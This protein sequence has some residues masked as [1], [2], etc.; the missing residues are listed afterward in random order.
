V[1]I[2]DEMIC[3]ATAIAGKT[4]FS[5]DI[6]SSAAAGIGR[7]LDDAV[8]L[9]S[10]V[11]IPGAEW[12]LRLPLRSSRRFAR[13]RAH[14][15]AAIYGLIG[16]RR[17][18]P[19]AGHDLLSMLLQAQDS[20]GDGERMTDHQVRDEALTLFLTALDTVSLSLTWVW[21]ALARNPG[22][23]MTLWAELEQVLGGRP[24]AVEDLGSLP[25]TRMVLSETLRLYPPIYAIA[26]E[27]VAS[28][29][30]DGY[31]VA[32]GTL[33]LMSPYVMQRD[34]RYHADPEDF[35]PSRWDPAGGV[36]PPRFSYFPFGGGP[37]GCIGQ[38]YA[39]QEAMLVIATLAQRWRL[40]LVPG[41]SVVLR[42]LL[43]L[44]PANGIRMIVEARAPRNGS[45]DR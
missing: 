16:E 24:P 17:R 41:H 35:N 20:E 40:R 42:P 23:E 26:R 29:V 39:L 30:V 9:F 15:D 19:G 10:R 3:L 27:A 38:A 12:L 1:D 43:N 36:K 4:M 11:S 21:Y 33:V 44:R 37:R 7:A 31:T 8:S 25:F 34:P 2:L 6:D 18:Q 13:A 14:L 32:A 22:A 45:P 5:W 28:F